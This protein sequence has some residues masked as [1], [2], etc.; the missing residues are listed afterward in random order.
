VL[1]VRSVIR[2]NRLQLFR[3]GKTRPGFMHLE[4][5]FAAVAIWLAT[6]FL[7]VSAVGQQS[8]R[9]PEA[10]EYQNFLIRPPGPSFL[11][12]GPF[13][14]TI[15]V[16][17][18][19]N[20]NDNATTSD[21]QK[22]S[23]NQIFE[24]VDL[25]LGW[26]LS[27]FNRVEIAFNGQ[28][29][30]N[31]YSNGKEGIN[32]SIFPG[33]NIQF[34]AKIGD[35]LLR[36][37]EQ[38]AIEQDPVTDPAITGQTTLNRLTNTAGLGVTVPFYPFEV[39]LQFDYT[40]SDTLGSTNVPGTTS[41]S[42]FG[43]G[44]VRNTLRLGASLGYAFSSFVS[45]GSEFVAATNYGAGSS[46]GQP[47]SSGP[48]LMTGGVEFNATTSYG[49]GSNDVQSVSV[50]PFLKGSL[51]RLIQIDTGVGLLLLS[52]PLFNPTQFYAYFSLR[53]QITPIS[54]LVAGVSHDVDFSSGL[55]ITKN[56]NFHLDL[57]TEPIRRLVLTLGPFVNFG[58]TQSGSQLDSFTQYGISVESRFQLSRQLGANFSYRFAWRDGQQVTDRYTQNVFGMSLE[59]KF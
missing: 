33:S 34:Q 52:A 54:Q 27:P 15:G 24:G 9:T 19:Y 53:Y 36:T 57:R 48:F 2:V 51:T 20:F 32:L 55:N 18:G 14:G 35:V 23:Q 21:T 22:I 39:G 10:P 42:S 25:E 44:T 6:I 59:Y 29:Q 31:F 5:F 43:Q 17:G 12:L 3:G 56:N 4:R 50:G 37:F 38:F 7:A 46:G 30:E 40:Y 8:V 11:H 28:L 58:E 26:T 1:P 41:T 47:E 49:A 13:S 16:S 45:G